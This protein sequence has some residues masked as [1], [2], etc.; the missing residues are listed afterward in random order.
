[1]IEIPKPDRTYAD[2]SYPAYSLKAVESL[3]NSLGF[4]IKYF[5]DSEKQFIVKKVIS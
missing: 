3:L 2:H 1:M 4:E 5:D